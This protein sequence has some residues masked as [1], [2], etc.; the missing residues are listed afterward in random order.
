MLKTLKKRGGVNIDTIGFAAVRLQ[1]FHCGDYSGTV[2]ISS[3][4]LSGRCGLIATLL[5]LSER[6][7]QS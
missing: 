5:Q 7:E 2:K 1:I 6:K 3:M 4:S